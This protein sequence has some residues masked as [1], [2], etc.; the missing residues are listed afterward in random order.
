MCVQTSFLIY[1]EFNNLFFFQPDLKQWV[2]SFNEEIEKVEQ[3]DLIVTSP[4]KNLT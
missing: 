2:D 3:T 4:S 1:L